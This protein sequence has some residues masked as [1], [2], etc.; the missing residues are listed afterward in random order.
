MA[1]G[2]TKDDCA[3]T[4]RLPGKA[5]EVPHANCLSHIRTLRLLTGKPLCTA[6][7]VPQTNVDGY[8]TLWLFRVARDTIMGYLQ[9]VIRQ[10]K[11]GKRLLRLLAFCEVDVF[12]STNAPLL[13]DP[14]DVLDDPHDYRA[15]EN[16]EA[17]NH[18]PEHAGRGEDVVGR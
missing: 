4:A 16:D 6:L 15:A 17:D 5:S 8:S 9:G 14:T 11:A 3:E 2:I 7:S 12:R 10:Q 13:A 18:C 1:P